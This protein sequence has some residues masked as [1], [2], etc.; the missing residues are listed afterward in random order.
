MYPYQTH[1]YISTIIP[2]SED[3]FVYL[4]TWSNRVICHCQRSPWLN[5]YKPIRRHF[6]LESILLNRSAALYF[7]SFENT[8]CMYTL[9]MYIGTYVG[10]S[11]VI[12][13][14]CD[15]C[16][17]HN[18]FKLHVIKHVLLYFQYDSCLYWLTLLC[19]MYIFD[20]TQGSNQ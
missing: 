16:R 19:T 5:K 2:D 10:V 17:N 6:W 14:I 20:M 12:M 4:L 3:A 18:N 11:T 1:H 13:L 9:G 8:Y 15:T 7:S